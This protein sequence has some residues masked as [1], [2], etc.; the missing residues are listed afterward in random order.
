MCGLF[1][2]LGAFHPYIHQVNMVNG[3]H[4]HPRVL[5]SIFC[6]ACLKCWVKKFGKLS[7]E[8]ASSLERQPIPLL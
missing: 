1:E 4:P 2:M 5:I 6:A 7:Q 8:V 3:T